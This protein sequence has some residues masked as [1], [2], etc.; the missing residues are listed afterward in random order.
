MSDLNPY[1]SPEADVK[2]EKPLVSQG[3]LT[4]VMLKYLGDAS[5]W[6]RFLGIMG[7]IGSGLMV[8][9]G[10][11]C[12]TFLPFAINI[13]DGAS[14]FF[15]NFLAPMSVMVLYSL[16]FIGA[17]VLMFFP[18]LFTYRF[19][20]KIRSFILSNSETE[21]ELAFRNNKFL[22]KF[23]GILMIIGIAVVPVIIIIGVIA[24]VAFLALN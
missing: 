9:G 8:L 24:A 13:F 2:I 14:D 1:R 12:I 23:Q 5:P 15:S 17:G 6:L 16:Y 19:G 10:L 22:W 11:V 7:F 3:A 20:S 21:L 18:A 4:G